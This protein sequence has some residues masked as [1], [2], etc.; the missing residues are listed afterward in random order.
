[1]KKFIQIAFLLSLAPIAFAD[2]GD[3]KGSKDLPRGLSS[4]LVDVIIQLNTTAG[5]KG[6][7]DQLDIIEDMV[8]RF[9]PNGQQQRQHG[10]KMYNSIWTKPLR[11]IR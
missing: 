10:D 6:L 1:M 3:E 7:Q 11:G 5:S 8:R 2:K 4:A 9:G